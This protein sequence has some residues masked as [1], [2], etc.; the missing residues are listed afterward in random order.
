[1][2]V[3][4]ELDK[5]LTDAVADG[6]QAARDRIETEARASDELEITFSCYAALAAWGQ[7]G[8]AVI[9][10]VAT[11]GHRVK[12]KSGALT[13]LAALA[14]D[15]RVPT[16]GMYFIQQPLADLINSKVDAPA[17]RAE[18]RHA[19]RML[20]MSVPV[21][22][23]LIPVSQSFMHCRVGQAD[24][25]EEL[26]MALST[27]WL[28][29]G[30]PLLEKFEQMLITHSNDEPAFQ[31][32][33]C[34]Y[35][36]LLDPMAVQVWSQPDFH[37]ALEPDFVVRRADDSYVVIEIECPA[38]QLVTGGNRL[39][40][41]ATHAESQAVEYEDFL[42]VR[43]PEARVHFP[44]FRRAECLAVVG[45]ERTLQAAQR[46]ALLRANGRRQNSKVVGFDWLLGRARAVVS[47][48]GE[49][50]IEVIKGHRII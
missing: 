32:F 34:E 31:S 18:A 33:F 27:K 13:L 39:S 44:N 46:Q 48:V 16:A 12:C 29:I 37:G 19:L 43:A 28:K 8:L 35:P 20:V 15:G 36:Q 9:V 41:Y 47:N 17:M 3:F 14:V 24:H 5:M 4:P 38:K 7:E 6:G 22:D 21:D 10:R 1:M 42:S 23:L 50:R 45:V 40:Q 2:F 26:V 30:P 11:A 25:A 49:G